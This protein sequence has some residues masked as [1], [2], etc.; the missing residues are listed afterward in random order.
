MTKEEI[1]NIITKQ[2]TLFSMEMSK[3]A[4]FNRQVLWPIP[5]VQIEKS[6]QSYQIKH[7]LD[8]NLLSLNLSVTKASFSQNTSLSIYYDAPKQECNQL[9]YFLRTN[10]IN[11]CLVNSKGV[12][13]PA[14]LATIK[15]INK[16]EARPLKKAIESIHLH[17]KLPQY[18]QFIHIS[19]EKTVNDVSSIRLH[20]ST[21]LNSDLLKSNQFLGN[22]VVKTYQ[23]LEYGIPFKQDEYLHHYPL[24]L[25]SDQ[26]VIFSVEDVLF[27][28]QN[29]SAPHSLNMS[30]PTY[31]P[32]EKEKQ[33]AWD[34][35]QHIFDKKPY[36]YLPF[37]NKQLITTPIVYTQ[38]PINTAKETEVL[39][40][41]DII[42]LNQEKIE[43]FS[44]PTLE[45]SRLLIDLLQ[46]ICSTIDYSLYSEFVS[47]ITSCQVKY[48]NEVIDVQQ[49]KLW[50]NLRV[51]TL[52][53]GMKNKSLQD[54][55]IVLLLIQQL[56]VFSFD[57]IDK[58]HLTVINTSTNETWSCP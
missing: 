29:M 37:P 30:Q 28:D 35:H 26:Q 31:I 42:Q 10:L 14:K 43:P 57:H 47:Q 41:T 38:K 27:L 3:D 46:S 22:I 18:H 1:E 13:H 34:V 58:L 51:I 52:F 9:F 53:V 2:L 36:L 6:E 40:Q 23:Q 39:F 7:E 12:R 16:K 19:T 50:I 17:Q 5:A 21:P 15:P 56:L 54:I 4:S 33:I 24:T 45:S 55:E 44:H 48:E 8:S 20:F 32:E 49:E 11:I 25:K